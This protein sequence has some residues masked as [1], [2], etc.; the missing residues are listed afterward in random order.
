MSCS[1]MGTQQALG[2]M[3]QELG[4]LRTFHSPNNEHH[5]MGLLVAE[6]LP[7]PFNKTEGEPGSWFC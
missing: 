5:Y 6:G 7:F 2:E 4:C 3:L 1:S